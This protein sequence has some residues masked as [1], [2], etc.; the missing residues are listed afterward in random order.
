MFYLQIFLPA[1]LVVFLFSFGHILVENDYS[2]VYFIEQ[3]EELIEEENSEAPNTTE[4]N[5]E[6]AP[7]DGNPVLPDKYNYLKIENVFTGRLLDT[8][9]LFSFELAIATYQTN[10]TADF[11]IKAI[12][13]YNLPENPPSIKHPKG[14][15]NGY[16][17]I[18]DETQVY[19]SGDTED[20]QEMRNLQNIDVAFVCMN[21]PYTMDINQAASAVLEFQPKIIYPYHYRGSNGFSDIQEF[22]NL[23]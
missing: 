19:I 2:G 10:V 13:M 6:N 23:I 15:G 20:I 14:R 4:V 17:L 22:K 9:E 7:G 11:F 8:K 5:S 1:G 18:I 21:L 3:S 12:P 16:I